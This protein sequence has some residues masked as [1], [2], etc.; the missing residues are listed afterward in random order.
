MRWLKSL[1]LKSIFHC[2]TENSSIHKVYLFVDI[3]KYWMNDNAIYCCQWYQRIVIFN[4]KSAHSKININSVFWIIK[5]IK[6]LDVNQHVEIDEMK[7]DENQKLN[8]T[9]NVSVL[10]RTHEKSWKRKI[11]LSFAVVTSLS[12]SENSKMWENTCLRLWILPL[13]YRL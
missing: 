7:W 11:S 1:I 13:L 12:M 8:S 9:S 5:T 2:M 10:S 4:L 6:L 3:I